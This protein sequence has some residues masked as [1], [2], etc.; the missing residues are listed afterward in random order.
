MFFH[1]MLFSRK[2]AVCSLS[3]CVSFILKK[4]GNMFGVMVNIFCEKRKQAVTIPSMR[5]H[6]NFW[7]TNFC[8]P[9]EI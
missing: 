7:K 5:M 6:E 1:V 2:P 9:Q 4:N 8:V 3:N